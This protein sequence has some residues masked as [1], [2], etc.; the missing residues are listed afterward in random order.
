MTSTPVYTLELDGKFHKVA[1]THLSYA[2]LQ[3]WA[4]KHHSKYELAWL[5]LRVGKNPNILCGGSTMDHIW[6]QKFCET[7]RINAM[8]QKDVPKG[9]QE[10]I[11]MQ[12][13]LKQPDAPPP[14]QRSDID[15]VRQQ[16]NF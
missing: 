4:R 14:L 11:V 8:N 13:Q 10:V 16:L 3:T 2:N 7:R 1:F 12:A 6:T 5:G 9:F 15:D